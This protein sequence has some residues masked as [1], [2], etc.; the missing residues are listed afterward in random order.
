MI[1]AKEK[2]VESRRRS[3]RNP[4]FSLKA[5]GSEGGLEEIVKTG[6]LAFNL[7]IPKEEGNDKKEQG[8]VR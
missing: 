1:I 2:G 6:E 4:Y 5:K 3:I 7:D 8:D